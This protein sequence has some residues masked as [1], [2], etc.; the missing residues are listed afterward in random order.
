MKLLIANN[1]Q[2]TMELTDL[3]YYIKYLTG[4]EEDVLNPANP[5]LRWVIYGNDEIIPF[6]S[7]LPVGDNMPATVIWR[8]HVGSPSICVDCHT[9]ANRR[10]ILSVGLGRVFFCRE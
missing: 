9:G 2:V 10:I 4:I 7:V 3:K 5:V 8:I 1:K 6:M